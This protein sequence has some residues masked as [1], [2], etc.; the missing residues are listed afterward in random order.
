M[1]ARISAG[2]RNTGRS[3]L[4]WRRTSSHP[5]IL[6][7]GTVAVLARSDL[8]IWVTRI[9]ICSTR[10]LIIY[11]PSNGSPSSGEVTV[12]GRSI[13][14]LP[15]QRPGTFGRVQPRS[16][17]EDGSLTEGYNFQD[18]SEL[19]D[20]VVEKEEYANVES[21]AGRVTIM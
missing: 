21:P 10:S 11:L 12:S 1:A 13:P 8:E 20:L 2:S 9:S 4:A 17:I 19:Q 16:A 15:S 18:L 7:L 3:L 14:R 6:Q 5:P